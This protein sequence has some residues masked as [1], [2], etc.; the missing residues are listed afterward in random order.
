VRRKPLVGAD[1]PDYGGRRSLTPPRST[2]SEEEKHEHP[3]HK[4]DRLK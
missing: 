4:E 1:L 3:Q 2:N